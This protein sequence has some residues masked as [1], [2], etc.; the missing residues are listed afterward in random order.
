MYTPALSAARTGSHS[1]SPQSQNG[2]L[3]KVSPL[4]SKAL[5]VPVHRQTGSPVHQH[6]SIPALLNSR[7]GHILLAGIPSSILAAPP[8]TGFFRPPVR[9][10]GAGQ[11]QKTLRIA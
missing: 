4:K 6:T 7:T 3:L 2:P 9:A 10:T 1:R 5:P 11:Q 8:D